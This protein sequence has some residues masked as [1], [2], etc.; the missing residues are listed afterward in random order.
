MEKM[1]P[2]RQLGR[3]GI[4]PRSWCSSL[5]PGAKKPRRWNERYGVTIGC[6]DAHGS[7]SLGEIALKLKMSGSRPRV[8]HGAS[9]LEL[10]RF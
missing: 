1:R 2:F 6:D 8:G 3:I 5:R 9:S 4:M 10:D 7:Y